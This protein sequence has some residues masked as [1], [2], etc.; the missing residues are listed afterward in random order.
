LE[1]GPLLK[2]LKNTLYHALLSSKMIDVSMS[3]SHPFDYALGKKG[4]SI[5]IQCKDDKGLRLALSFLARIDL[6]DIFNFTENVKE[7]FSL[8]AIE[9]GRKV[10]N[11]HEHKEKALELGYSHI[12]FNEPVSGVHAIKTGLRVSNLSEK[13]FKVAGDHDFYVF[14]SEA[15]NKLHADEDLI[16][17]D[18]F[19]RELEWLEA[20]DRQ[21]WYELPGN[22]SSSTIKAL[23][24]R[25]KKTSLIVGKECI[26]KLKKESRISTSI[27]VAH[28]VRFPLWPTL[29]NEADDSL[30]L[31]KGHNYCGLY[32]KVDRLPK[33][34]GLLDLNLWA[35]AQAQIR[36]GSTKEWTRAWLNKKGMAEPLE[37]A[38]LLAQQFKVKLNPSKTL[39]NK[40]LC[41]I[42]LLEEK[43]SSPQF[44]AFFRDARRLLHKN[45]QENQI[46][47]PYVL[48]DEDFASSFYTGAVAQ[49]GS[50]IR[51]QAE[52]FVKNII[53]D[54]ELGEDLKGIYNQNTL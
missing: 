5:Q 6:N 16:L 43:T 21:V 18:V 41:E 30:A 27:L 14:A 42:Q 19:K 28:E 9:I 52:V 22:I 38:S 26:E 33:E 34:E 40:L 54:S 49:G 2:E 29:E 10:N 11:C 7:K 44:T 13:G 25:A 51:T 15:E 48:R 37:E 39:F 32:L 24:I 36:G 46:N 4:K 35:L 3:H 12:I 47:I 31:M 20:S 8:R 50:S 17:A 45:L 1:P 23:D 53:D